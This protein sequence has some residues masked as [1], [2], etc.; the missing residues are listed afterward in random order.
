MYLKY[1]KN[2]RL[3]ALWA[4]FITML[5]AIPGKDI[6]QVSWFEMLSFDKLVHAS[7]FAILVYLAYH[8][9]YKSSQLACYIAEPIYFSFLICIIYYGGI[10]ELMQEYFFVD[11]KADWYDFYANAIGA[12]IGAVAY[13]INNSKIAHAIEN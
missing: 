8:A 9:I 11:R 10:L 7:L 6:P 13:K 5:C 4:L 3:T 2:F 12:M 1:I